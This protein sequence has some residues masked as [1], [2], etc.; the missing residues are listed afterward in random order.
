[1]ALGK[2]EIRLELLVTRDSLSG[3]ATHPGGAAREFVGWVGL[4]AAIDVL[5]RGGVS[6]EALDADP[7]DPSSPAHPTTET[8]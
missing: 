7:D 1:M 8:G 5:V 2:H 4:V 6:A 3:R